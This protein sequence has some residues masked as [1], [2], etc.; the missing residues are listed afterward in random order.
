MTGAQLTT[1]VLVVLLA[2]IM[3]TVIVLT[4]G[5]ARR[6]AAV[7]LLLCA[8]ASIASWT[9]N[10]SFQDIYVD[11]DLNATS[12]SRTKVH[13]NRPFHFHE[14]VHYYLGPKYFR[15]IGYL[16]LYDCLTLA[17]RE[18]AAEEHHPPRITG[19]VRDLADILTDK[20]D[21][22]SMAQCRAGARA[23]FSDSRWASFK[24]DVREL[25]RLA[26]DRR[27][28]AVIFDAGYNAPPS[29]LVLSQPLTNWIPIR[30]GPWPTYLV[31]TGID[32]ILLVVCF[33][34]MRVGFGNITALV[35]VTF[36][37]ASFVSDYSWNGGSVLRFMWVVALVL[38]IVALK[39]ER[40]ALAGVLF[41]LAT[42]DRLFPVA[43]AVAAMV[44]LAVRARR[45]AEYRAVL[46]TF[47][48]YFGG[49]VVLFVLASIIMF[50]VSEWNVFFMRIG[51]HDDVYHPLSLGLKK[52]LTFR[53][54][55]PFQNFH[56]HEG[57]DRYRMWNLAL[58]ETWVSMRPIVVPLQAV[59]AAATVWAASRRRPYEAALLGGVVFMFTFSL[60][61]NYYYCI[62][63][64][65]PALALRAAATARTVE[66]RWRDFAVYVF[67]ALFW[68]FTFLAPTLPGD[69]ITSNHRISMALFAFVL[70]WTALWSD[71]R[72]SRI[73]S[74]LPE[75]G[76][77]G[78]RS[79]ASS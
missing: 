33:L 50:G 31:A 77:P 26:E 34:M 70:V 21:E 79:V 64:L 12:P 15:E 71:F 66:Q 9:R 18:I 45:S 2:S 19:P 60:P 46:R 67:F 52:V 41:G 65:I 4:R 57:N 36:F 11:A 75:K 20:T 30:A 56:G 53:D 25:A 23:R 69:D 28:N 22:E 62:L 76:V 8:V 27:W 37:G 74:F 72:P 43:F 29:S 54:W 59:V 32:L 51:R 40:W 55:V 14:F 3:A 44:P 38:G 42:C 6:W 35:F 78:R 13:Q 17:D 1:A 48:L 24:D 16:A 49:I 47:A 39:K 7:V 61:S 10:G 5:R 73:W 58:R 68:T 63:A